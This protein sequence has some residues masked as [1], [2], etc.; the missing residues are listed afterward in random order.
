MNTTRHRLTKAATCLLLSMSITT[1][2]FAQT[3]FPN[4]PI[5]LVIPSA[6]GGLT[7]PIARFFSA[8]FQKVW[9]QPGVVEHHP[10]AGGIIGTQFVTKAAPDGYT[11]LIGNIGPLVFT[12]ALNP[13]TPY[14]VSRDLAPV[15]SLIRF[16][17]VMLVN[18]TVK[19]TSVSELIQLA[20]QKPG[21]IYF[22]SAGNG[23]SQHLSGELFKRT[24]GIEITHVPYKGTGPATT[25]LIGGQVQL[26][27][28]NI[29]SALPFIKSGQLR[30]LAVTGSLRS[31]A[32]PNVPTVEESG[33]PGFIVNSWVA[34]L[35]PAGT[36]KAIIDSINEETARAW[37][38]PEGQ[39]IL[40]ANNLEF[41]KGSQADLGSF[42]DNESMRWSKLIREANI[43]GD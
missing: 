13:K 42:L 34:L 3:S 5:R 10:G 29:P 18:P 33:L 32:L 21:S 28:G 12:P 38:T 23:Q 24:A 41:A 30:A 4:A 25:D 15:G 40:L 27:F 31:V 1:A 36:P 35:A 19:A 9:G 17:N 43:K 8:H 39:A 26:M 20:K 14:V 6:P 7:D 2:I 11:L 37:A 16:A 22:S